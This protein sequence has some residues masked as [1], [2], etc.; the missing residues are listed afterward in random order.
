MNTLKWIKSAILRPQ[1]TSP[2]RS[3]QRRKLG[4]IALV[5]AWL[6]QA[7]LQ[8]AHIFDRYDE[9]DADHYARTNPVPGNYSNRIV[10]VAVSEDDYRDLFHSRSPL[11]AKTLLNL[12]TTVQSYNPRAIGVDFLTADWP[13]PLSPSLVGTTPRVVWARDGRD[14]SGESSMGI[15]QLTAWK[16]VVGYSTPPVGLCFAAPVNQPDPDSAVRHY[17]TAVQVHKPGASSTAMFPTMAQVLA[18]AYKNR[19]L[20]CQTDPDPAVKIIQFTGERHRFRVLFAS[21]MVRDANGARS[22]GKYL[23]SKIVLLGGTFAGRDSYLSGGDY[24]PGVNILAN[25]IESELSGS[26]RELSVGINLIISLA[27]SVVLYLLMKPLRPPLDVL[28]SLAFLLVFSFVTG[29]FTY[30][31]LHLFVP[32]ASAL[33]S[34]PIGIIFEHHVACRHE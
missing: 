20:Y 8:E 11:D 32:L 15:P 25:A 22:F 26:I 29:Y 10:I 16:G 31:Y 6:A 24:R 19:P 2:T 18:S 23:D 13:K 30:R 7:G 21:D 27:V 1:E 14:D 9:A 28:L 34:L 4:L 12:V 3:R 17:S 33:F 5:L